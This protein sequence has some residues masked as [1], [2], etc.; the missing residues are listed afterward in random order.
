VTLIGYA[1]ASGTDM[2]SSP[3]VANRVVARIDALGHVDT[4]TILPATAFPGVPVHAAVSENGAAFWVSGTGG[5]IQFYPKGSTAT[6]PLVVSSTPARVR[7]L[8]TYRGQLYLSSA[9]PVAGIAAISGGLPV[10]GPQT[11][12]ALPG[13]EKMVSD[14][15]AF[16]LFTRGLPTATKPDVIY[17]AAGAGGI[18]RWQLEADKWNLRAT[19]SGAP[20]SPLYG[21][22]AETVG[23]DVVLHVTTPTALFKV[24][25]VGGTSATAVITK[26]ADAPSATSSEFRGV[27][28]GPT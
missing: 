24:V 4:S 5:G 26:I 14:P 10:V 12:S 1:A 22:A 8:V 2:V 11:V 27:A 20:L 17:V 9:T 23:A 21:L 25:D 16:A 7:N 6:A 18:Q 19:F 28:L 13:L 3:G 15:W